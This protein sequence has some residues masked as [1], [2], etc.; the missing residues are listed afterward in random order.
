MQLRNANALNDQLPSRGVRVRVMDCTVVSAIS[1]FMINPGEPIRLIGFQLSCVG[2]YGM[3]LSTSRIFN[4][5]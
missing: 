4:P 3:A 5:Y 2:G 1:P